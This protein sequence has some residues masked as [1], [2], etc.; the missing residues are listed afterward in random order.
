MAAF[1]S[2]SLFTAFDQV[3]WNA[4]QGPTIDDAYE[5]MPNETDSDKLRRL[6]LE[7]SKLKRV[8]KLMVPPKPIKDSEKGPICQIGFYHNS[9]S[10]HHKDGL[11]KCITEFIEEAEKDRE[12]DIYDQLPSQK[13][14]IDLPSHGEDYDDFKIIQSIQI[15]PDGYIVDR[16][17]EP[18]GSLDPKSAKWTLPVYEG[19]YKDTLSENVEED[20][21][22]VEATKKKMS[23]CCFNCGSEKHGIA[24]CTEPRNP[25]AINKRKEEFKAMFGAGTPRG[26][27]I[28]LFEAGDGHSSNKKYANFKPGVISEALHKACGFKPTEIP[29]WIYYFRKF[30]YPPGWLDEALVRESGVQVRDQEEGEVSELIIHSNIESRVV[31]GLDSSKIIE[32]PGF[33]IQMPEGIRDDFGGDIERLTPKFYKNRFIETYCNRNKIEKMNFGKKRKPSEDATKTED[34]AKKVKIEEGETVKMEADE[35]GTVEEFSII[36]E[37]DVE[38]KTEP[39][40]DFVAGWEAREEMETEKT[41][42]VSNKGLPC[43]NKWSTGIV[44]FDHDAYQP[45]PTQTG[46]YSKLKDALKKIR[47]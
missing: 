40:T 16:I 3:G 29:S 6:Q 41:E 19:L 2:E 46:A 26:P 25:E 33:N 24:A 47:E 23:K 27:N 43:R 35:N 9:L 31:K 21:V 37:I 17:G 34:E 4:A 13:A 45:Q 39:E 1:G 38:P 5:E 36:D 14:A 20:L 30:G 42:G 18:I 32:Y 28:R 10:R 7:N 15:F 12:M 8:V 44:A 22:K 11:I